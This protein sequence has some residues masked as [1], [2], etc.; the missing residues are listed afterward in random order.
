METTYECMYIIRNREL[1]MVKFAT[2]AGLVKN[3][4]SFE[5][6]SDFSRTPEKD[7][8]GTGANRWFNVVGEVVVF[9]RKKEK[10]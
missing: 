8:E 5:G 1:N 2:G 9:A 4:S 3:F 10:W 7:F 6:F